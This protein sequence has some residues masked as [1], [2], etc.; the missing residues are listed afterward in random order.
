MS[1]EVNGLA[2][3]TK[4]VAFLLND[5]VNIFFGENGSGKTSLLKILY[6][7]L[8]DDVTHIRRVPFTSATVTF[9]PDTKERPITRTISSATVAQTP[10]N[11]P[12]TIMTANG[13]VTFPFSGPQRGWI[14]DLSP[15]EP[16]PVS[17]LSIFRLFG[18]PNMTF[19]VGGPESSPYSESRLDQQFLQ[20]V[21]NRWV[22]YSNTLLSQVKTLQDEG[23]TGL[24]GSL[25]STA[26]K[27][28]ASASDSGAAY[29]LVRHFFERRNAQLPVARSQ[30]S[31]IYS[32]NQ[33]LRSALRD[34]EAIE[35]QI[36]LAERPRGQLEQ[37]VH[38]FLTNNKRIRFFEGGIDVRVGEDTTIGI[39]LLAS[40]EKQLIRILLECLTA[41]GNCIIIDEP[42][43]SLHI[44][45]QHELVAAM[46]TVNQ[47]VQI[48]MATHSPEIM[49]DVED[50]RIFQLI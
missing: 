9:M 30:F 36:L 4:P 21:M 32:E 25:F 26:R 29:V 24:L 49:A 27:R 41:L 40:G 13:P 8:Q 7:A 50:S 46:R 15:G 3:R 17:Y 14:S 18:D 19:W 1:F 37:V 6:S 5:D 34:I 42:E 47:D 35:R 45:W 12:T 2:G 48:I 23:L 16:A 11:P 28:P 44:D 22:N 33:S 20:L 10:I 38:R 39:D 43:L 31:R